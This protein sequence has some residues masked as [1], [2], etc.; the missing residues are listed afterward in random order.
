MYIVST[1]IGDGQVNYVCETYGQASMLV[2]RVID[3][4]P[5]GEVWRIYR[6]TKRDCGWFRSSDDAAWK[7]INGWRDGV[8][9]VLGAWE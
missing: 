5:V 8:V 7:H 3:D 1:L 6:N 9:I 4:R 2:D